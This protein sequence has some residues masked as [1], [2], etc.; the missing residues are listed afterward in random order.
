MLKPPKKDYEK[1][2]KILEDELVRKQNRIE[3]LENHNKILL[4][5]ALKVQGKLKVE[6]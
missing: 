2:I 1:I 5:T 4:K 3:E 6:K